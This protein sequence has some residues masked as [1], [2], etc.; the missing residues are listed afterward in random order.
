MPV[1]AK[2]AH[3]VLKRPKR[4]RP[5]KWLAGNALMVSDPTFTCSI[6]LSSVQRIDAEVF[7]DGA[8]TQRSD[9]ACLPQGVHLSKALHGASSQMIVVIVRN[10]HGV[11]GR[12]I[13]SASGG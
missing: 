3:R 11:D 5:E 13:P 12:Q 7:Q 1:R 8:H 6:Q 4:L 9:P 10:K 2:D